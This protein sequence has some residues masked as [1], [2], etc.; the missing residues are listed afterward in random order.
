MHQKITNEWLLWTVSERVG[1]NKAEQMQEDVDKRL[2]S[3][4]Q[5]ATRTTHITAMCL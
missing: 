2:D 5:R 1:R 4:T 3:L